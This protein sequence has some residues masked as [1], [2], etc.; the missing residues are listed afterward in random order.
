M[1][2]EKKFIKV[3]LAI[4]DSPYKR[5]SEDE[6]RVLL[7]N[8]PKATWH[9]HI[10]TL[11]KG[12]IPILKKV[13]NTEHLEIYS[14]QTGEIT[15][16]PKVYYE[17]KGNLHDLAGLS[18]EETYVLESYK[19]LGYLLDAN[20]TDI[21]FQTDEAVTTKDLNELSRKFFYLSKVT[22][23]PFKESNKK[24]FK[25]LINSLLNNK[26][27]YLFYPSANDPNAERTRLIK[28]MTICHYKDDLYLMGHEE[29]LQCSSWEP[30]IYKISRIKD[31]QKTNESFK[32]P[33][34]NK[35]NPKDEYKHASGII[36]GKEKSAQVKVYSHM[37][38]ILKEKN[39]MNSTLIEEYEDYDI[40]HFT[41]TSKAEFLGQ[42]FVWAENVE[43]QYPYDLKEA[44]IRKAQVALS[45][46]HILKKA[47]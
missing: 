32:Y 31:L 11:T 22:A 9:R 8:P 13:K 27:I 30:R 37:R 29:K 40:Y 28:P 41:Y 7:D 16:T 19:H 15:K 10:K 5:L 12:E 20:L 34:K 21:P 24:A 25:V 18:K 6:L 14:A 47:S 4:L 38:K 33:S 26:M 36:R 17:L 39:I 35:W 45:R 44:F 1:A 3:L 23:K 42:L 43:I 46:N 2:N